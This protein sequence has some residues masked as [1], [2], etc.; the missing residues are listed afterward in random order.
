[1][2]FLSLNKHTYLSIK[3]KRA[4]HTHIQTLAC[5]H[6]IYH[7]PNIHL[8]SYHI[9]HPRPQHVDIKGSHWEHE[10]H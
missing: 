10:D 6:P 5:Y 8:A 2:E 7:P 1:M 3:Q 4:K 9:P